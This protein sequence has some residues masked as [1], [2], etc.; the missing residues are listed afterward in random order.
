MLTER[1]NAS[2]QIVGGWLKKWHP[3]P[4]WAFFLVAVL[5]VIL[6]RAAAAE[7][8]QSRVLTDG[9]QDYEENCI[10]CHGA[11]ATGMGELGKKL[12][13]PP[14]DL[15]GIATR[16]GGQFPFWRVFDIIAGEVEVVGHE[17]FQMPD[18]FARMRG[19]E[20]KPGYLPAH[21]RILELTHYLESIQ[22][23]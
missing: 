9:R 14:K 11:D 4:I 8:V 12:I 22:K 2:S 13:K 15:T 1:R 19:E 7:D 23:K 18:Y 5:L 6:A 3:W 17:T 10:A 20:R 16:S 21:V